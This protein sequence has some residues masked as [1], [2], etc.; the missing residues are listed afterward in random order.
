MERRIQAQEA[1]PESFS[2]SPELVA[3]DRQAN[4][5]AE[6]IRGLRTHIMA[7]H[8]EQGR[9]AVAVCAATEAVG[10]SFVAANLALA[11]SQIGVKT[12][13][14]DADL[15]RPTIDTLFKPSW[16]ATGL[17]QC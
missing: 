9:R 15:R 10:C 11:L 17:T 3:L 12:L 14:I 13:L 16:Q 7:R 8:V 6:S 2:L 4:I 1:N 5:R